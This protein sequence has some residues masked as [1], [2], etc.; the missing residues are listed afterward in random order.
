MYTTYKTLFSRTVVGKSF[1]GDILPKIKPISHNVQ[2]ATNFGTKIHIHNNKSFQSPIINNLY[3][4]YKSKST[5]LS[6]QLSTPLSTPLLA[7]L[8]K[9]YNV[10][11]VMFSSLSPQSPQSPQSGHPTNTLTVFNRKYTTINNHKHNPQ[12]TFEKRLE[13]YKSYNGSH[14]ES[15]SNNGRNEHEEHK[16]QSGYWSRFYNNFKVN[17]LDDFDHLLI[18]GL[19]FGIIGGIC[20][21]VIGNEPSEIFIESMIGFVFGFFFGAFL[22][23][24]ICIGIP[25]AIIRKLISTSK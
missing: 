1:G 9:Q 17:G 12:D 25:V 16:Q 10:P 5:P 6:T 19:F 22:P 24:V 3:R 18:V 20:G 23:I 13:K 11:C 21:G 7:S 2:L 4:N 8:V 15:N 14:F